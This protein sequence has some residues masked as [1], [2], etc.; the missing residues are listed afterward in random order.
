MGVSNKQNL[1]MNNIS[2]LL[3]SGFSIPAG[4]PYVN[5]LNERMGRIEE[6]EILIHGSQRAIFLNGAKDPNRWSGKYERLFLQDFLIFY[7]SEVLVDSEEFH[8]EKFYDF[9]SGYRR[10]QENKELIHK[11]YNAF[12][13]KYFEDGGNG[14]RDCHNRIADFART[15]SQLLAAQLHKL[16]YFED[17]NYTEVFLIQLFITTRMNILGLNQT[18]M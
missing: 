16:E 4:L 18:I 12:N 5:K 10:N 3:G 2:F 9:Y 11:F 17:I 7:N 1:S 13:E 8:Y 14:S 6:E 15:Y